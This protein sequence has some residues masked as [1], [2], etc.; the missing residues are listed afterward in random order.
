MCEYVHFVGQARDAME[1]LGVLEELQEVSGDGVYRAMVG[2]KLPWLGL[3][4][5]IETEDII[6]LFRSEYYPGFPGSGPARTLEILMG[7]VGPKGS[8]D[9]FLALAGQDNVAHLLAFTYGIPSPDS[10]P[11]RD[12]QLAARFP[13]AHA[14][15]FMEAFADK[16]WRP[17]SKRALNLT[18]SIHQL[19]ARL[20]N[21]Y[22]PRVEIHEITTDLLRLID[23]DP[24]EM[25]RLDP[26]TFEALVAD[27][28][29]AM[30]MGVKRVG[31]TNRKDGGVDILA[32]PEQLASVPFLIA[33]QVK[34][35]RRRRS[36][37]PQPVREL[38]GV[39]SRL[40]CEIG[41][42]VTNTAFT[43]DAQWAASNNS[44]IIR[45]RDMLDLMRWVRGDFLGELEW[46]EIP[47]TIEMAPGI[48]IDV[49]KWRFF[50]RNPP[51]AQKN[52]T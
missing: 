15:Q 22:R 16:V 18:S 21:E 35:T 29:R 32:W 10:D 44:T 33:V 38:Q 46:R 41:M 27:R 1:R 26:S 5:T 9:F 4:Y 34:H 40:P 51:D 42:L 30:G 52:G 3:P 17:H 12:L 20:K 50:T 45:L 11:S 25:S 2:E 49:P 7:G 23:E 47:D 6:A 14:S 37:G 8:G 24:N 13:L 43:A 28:L 48:R 31:E 19:A 39:L 36:L